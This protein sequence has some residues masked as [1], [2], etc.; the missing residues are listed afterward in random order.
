MDED[1]TI[2]GSTAYPYPDA[3]IGSA[4]HDQSRG[5]HSIKKSPMD[6]RSNKPRKTQIDRISEN[7][8]KK[9]FITNIDDEADKIRLRNEEHKNKKNM[10]AVEPFWQDFN[11]TITDICAEKDNPGSGAGR[12]EPSQRTRNMSKGKMN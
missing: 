4:G 12:R 5:F 10:T 8:T 9:K 1:G 2:G 3:S 6:M 7:L 11:S